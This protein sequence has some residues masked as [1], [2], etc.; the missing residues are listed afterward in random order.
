MN[1]SGAA[2]LPA[3]RPAPSEG[4]AA[5]EVALFVYYGVVEAQLPQALA[6]VRQR[7]AALAARCPGLIPSL[8]RRPETRPGVRGREGER[9]VTVMETYTRAGGVD[10]AT[11]AQI[12]AAFK[13]APW[14]VGPRHTER[15]L[16]L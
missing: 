16:P 1:P 10:A 8:W 6:G 5:A 12:E 3:G 7:Q 9:E 13:D 4:N 14:C 11:A 15:F 2:P